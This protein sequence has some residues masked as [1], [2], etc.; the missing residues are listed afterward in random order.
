MAKL[1]IRRTPRPARGGTIMLKV[2]ANAILNGRPHDT[3]VT[4]TT[5]VNRGKDYSK[6]LH[7]YSE[8]VEFDG[9]VT[10]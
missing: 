10:P 5:A 3:R 1:T 4:Y 7:E 9:L 2:P 6:K 8:D